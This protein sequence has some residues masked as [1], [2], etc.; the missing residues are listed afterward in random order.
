MQISFNL[1]WNKLI[2]TEKAAWDFRDNILMEV[3]ARKMKVVCTGV[4]SK[5]LP[6]LN[7]ANVPKFNT[8]PIGPHPIGS[9][10]VRQH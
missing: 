1:T 8:N 10:E 4:T 9:F 3:A 5:I 6:G 7:D 2:F